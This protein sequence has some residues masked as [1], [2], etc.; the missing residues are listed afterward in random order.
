MKVGVGGGGGSLPLK[1]RVQ[2]IKSKIGK[3]KSKNDKIEI[4]KN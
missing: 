2:M 4:N 1:E 3:D